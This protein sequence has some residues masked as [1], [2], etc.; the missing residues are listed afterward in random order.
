MKGRAAWAALGLLIIC[1]WRAAIVH[2]AQGLP[3]AI[4][5]LPFGAKSNGVRISEKILIGQ[6]AK[7]R[8]GKFNKEYVERGA[9]I[10]FGIV[11]GIF[12]GI[13]YAR[14]YLKGEPTDGLQNR[15]QRC[16][17]RGQ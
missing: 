2:E 10:F 4:E 13:Y 9:F 6:I 17:K 11:G 15:E 14:R 5:R 16:D 8:G 12:A 1:F 7:D 3:L